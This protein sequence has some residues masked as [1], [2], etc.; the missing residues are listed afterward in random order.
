MNT[1]RNKVSLIGRL[2]ANPELTTLESGTTLAKF[3][4]A[5]N[6]G[7]K[8]KSGEWVDVTQWHNIEA[9]GK[10][11]ESI[12]K[13]LEKGM[14]VMLEGKLNN[15]TYESKTGEKRYATSIVAN[16]FIKVSTK[17]ESK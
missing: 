6:E 12:S 16:E 1:L 3:S 15:T 5:T 10:L 14:E 4:I 13:H 7:Y 11:A 17:A 8:D 2:G 9:W